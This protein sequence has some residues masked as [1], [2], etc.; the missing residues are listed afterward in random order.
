LSNFSCFF[1]CT[2]SLEDSIHSSHVQD[3]NDISNSDSLACIIAKEDEED[4]DVYNVSDD[5]NTDRA[6][7]RNGE[8]DENDNDESDDEDKK[9]NKICSSVLNSILAKVIS[10]DTNEIVS[11]L[12]NVKKEHTENSTTSTTTNTTTD[13]NSLSSDTSKKLTTKRRK[14]SAQELLEDSLSNKHALSPK[15]LIKSNNAIQNN[16][17]LKN[18]SHPSKSPTKKSGTIS[19]LNTSSNKQVKIEATKTSNKI[20]PRT[21]RMSHQSCSSTCSNES[22]K[23]VTSQ[24]EEAHTCVRASARIRGS[25]SSSTTTIGISSSSFKSEPIEFKQQQKLP[26]TTENNTSSMITVRMSNNRKLHVCEKC[27]LEFTSGNSVLRHQEKSCLRV[28]IINLASIKNQHKETTSTGGPFKKK[29]PICSSIFF[30]THRLSIH[31]YKHH[32]NLLGSANQPPTHEAKRLNEIQLKKLVKKESKGEEEMEDEV[33][34]E[35]GEEEELEEEEE[36]S[37]VESSDELSTSI[38]SNSSKQKNKTVEEEETSRRRS[39]KRRKSSDSTENGN[40]PSYT[41]CTLES[42]VLE[43]T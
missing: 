21:T 30:N 32:R 4:D 14:R 39:V 2:E 40:I 28:R 29:C 13:E 23:K 35:D 31:I 26:K 16:T 27:D 9:I 33:E 19:A 37:H 6:S 7:P 43:Y 36:T 5:E 42:S 15:R 38:S 10:V 8:N 41:N 18:P 34:E 25:S 20:A 3:E 12:T 24:V 1:F 22:T 11:G 17:S